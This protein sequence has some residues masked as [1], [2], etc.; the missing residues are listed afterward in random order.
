MDQSPLLDLQRHFD[1]IADAYYEIVDRL[2]YDVGYYHR[3]EGELLRQ[4]IGNRLKLAIDAG[5]GPGK[6]TAFLAASSSR[7]VAVDISREMLLETR[8]RLSP[9]HRTRVHLIQADVRR[10]P[11]KAQIADCIANLEVLEHLPGALSDARTALLEFRRILMPGGILVVEAPLRR[12]TRWRAL[13]VKLP[14]WKEL[15]ASMLDRY[16]RKVPLTVEHLYKDEQIDAIL[17][18]AGFTRVT[19]TFVRVVPAGLVERH[20]R[21]ISIDRILE[22]TPGIKRFAREAVWSA[23]VSNQLYAAGTK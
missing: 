1:N 17:R 5:C 16:Y 11:L 10:L 9:E 8:A 23:K 22:R 2:W 13:G 19:K 6:H 15:P 4:K 12:H 3:R 18:E 20:P 14:T 7:V 21:L